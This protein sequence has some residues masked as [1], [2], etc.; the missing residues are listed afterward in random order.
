MMFTSVYKMKILYV[1]PSLSR[2]LQKL[3]Q[4]GVTLSLEGSIILLIL[5]LKRSSPMT[6][7]Y[8]EPPTR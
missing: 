6:Q 2:K 7:A 3:T 1:I 8:L 4:K 5:H